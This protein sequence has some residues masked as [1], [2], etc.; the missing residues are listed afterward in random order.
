MH[1]ENKQSL[2]FTYWQKMKRENLIWILFAGIWG[3]WYFLMKGTLTYWGETAFFQYGSLYWSGFANRPGGWTDYLANFLLQLYQWVGT[4]ALVQT[5]IVAAIFGLCRGINKTIG[6]VKPGIWVSAIPFTLVFLLQAGQQ[7]TLADSLRVLFLFLFIWGYVQCVSVKWRYVL[8]TLLFPLFF[9]MLGKEGVFVLYANFVLYEIVKPGNRYRWGIM[10]LWAGLVL[11]VPV[12]W[13]NWIAIMP[14]QDLFVARGRQ[15]YGWWVI[16]GYLVCLWGIGKIK[17]GGWRGKS[18][19]AAE[20]A[21]VVL[22][23][24]IGAYRFSHSLAEDRFRMEQAAEAGRWEEVLRLGRK[25]PEP[26]REDLYLLTLA[27]ANRGELGEHLFDYPVWGI[28]CLYLPKELH[29]R[30][31]VLGGELYYRLKIPNEALH[32]TFQAAVAAPQGMDFRTLKRLIELNV[33]KRDTLLADKYLSILENT[34]G[35]EAWCKEKRTELREPAAQAVLPDGAQDFFIG[36]RPFLSDMARV[37]DAGKS[38]EMVL[39]YLLC[40]LLLNKDLGKFCQLFTGFYETG[41]KRIPKVYQEALLVAMTID[42]QAVIQKDY[43]VDPEVNKKFLDYSALYR[44]YGKNKQQA[45]TLMKEFKNTWWY[46][47]HFAEPRTMD[48]QGHMLDGGQAYSL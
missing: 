4:G 23:C 2:S 38:R 3:F 32:W 41:G 37:L 35:Y 44:T 1:T 13:R 17:L 21:I 28:G 46:Y 6:W 31:S 16:Y 39:D 48:L 36:G 22:V 27:L 20:M 18:R 29:Y 19:I 42:N 47:F 12:I 24:G 30:T 10:V 25:M 15:G 43:L 5:L 11:I 7:M 8:F 45:Q 34:M 9:L 14:G 33:M 26:T 40:G